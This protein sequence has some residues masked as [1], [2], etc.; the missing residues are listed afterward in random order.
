MQ[1]AQAR[2]LRVP[3]NVRGG[4]WLMLAALLFSGM[5]ALI[6]LAGQSLHVTEILLFRQI[7][8]MLLALP[9]IVGGFPGSLRSERVGLQLL[10]IAAASA[11]MLLGFTA[12]IHL[13]L[14]E[15]ITIGFARTFFITIFAI[16]ILGEVVGMRRWSA[17]V[18]GFS[19]V[20][21]V[22]QPDFSGGMNV[23]SLM[24]I[25]GAAC[26]GLVMVL[27]RLLSRTDRPVT[28][29][30]YQALGVGLVVLPPALWFWKT[31]TLAELALLAAI[32]A[33]SALAQVVN[34]YA[35]RAGEASAIAPLD[36]TRLV[37]A[38]GFGLVL[39]GE[40]PGPHVFAGAAIIIAAGLYTMYREQRIGAR[41]NRDVPP[42]V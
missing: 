27:I 20:V 4:L 10:R 18:F 37:W 23:Y 2:W 1:H 38:T 7:F 16:L 26:G 42:P 28:I 34:I 22:A 40:W 8:M 21:V 24:A 31:P 5:V 15:A 11:A 19:G 12:F 17:M 29:L 13:H 14:A 9:V 35:F 33:V 36:Y 3:A 32:G 25:G 41:R 30:T 39:F 6:K